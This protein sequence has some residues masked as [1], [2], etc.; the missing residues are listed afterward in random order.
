MR[1]RACPGIGIE[2]HDEQ[3]PIRAGKGGHIKAMICPL[4]WR[5]LTSN[6][7]PTNEVNQPHLCLRLHRSSLSK[8][9]TQRTGHL[10]PARQVA[11]WFCRRMRVRGGIWHSATQG[12][13]TQNGLL[14]PNC[15]SPGC[16]T[17]MPPSRSACRRSEM[18]PSSLQ[19]SR[20]MPPV[21]C[22]SKQLSQRH[23]RPPCLQPSGSEEGGMAPRRP[24]RIVRSEMCNIILRS[25]PSPHRQRSG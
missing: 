18:S 22:Q 24:A 7:R 2:I 23:C 4:P 16:G 5:D 3:L 19:L 20:P 13:H 15:A 25:R 10:R 9:W 11:A 1:A 21:Q 17:T 6:N 14:P 12:P 8:R